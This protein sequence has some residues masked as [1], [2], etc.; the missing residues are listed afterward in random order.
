[1]LRS[2]A[3]LEVR[4]EQRRRHGISNSGSD[5]AVGLS[6]SVARF[7]GADRDVRDVEEKG[8]SS[9]CGVRCQR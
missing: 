5:S 3:G 4:G 7:G 8:S 1:M 6:G 2:V 9:G